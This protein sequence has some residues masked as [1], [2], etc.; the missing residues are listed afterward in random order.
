MEWTGETRGTGDAGYAGGTEEMGGTAKGG[1]DTVGEGAK[2]AAKSGVA[3]HASNQ[4]Q[5]NAPNPAMMNGMGLMQWGIVLQ[6]AVLLCSYS[7]DFFAAV[8]FLPRPAKGD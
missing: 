6:F 5:Q 4:Q 8:A 2:A 1:G 3:G 7:L